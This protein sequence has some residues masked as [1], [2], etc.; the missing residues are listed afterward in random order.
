MET[1]GRA[2]TLDALARSTVLAEESPRANVSRGAR[3]SGRLTLRLI[4]GGRKTSMGTA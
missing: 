4:K 2:A 1:R 3:Q